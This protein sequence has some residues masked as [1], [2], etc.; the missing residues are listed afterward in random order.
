[1]S[2]F[3]FVLSFRNFIRLFYVFIFLFSLQT[4][5]QEFLWICMLIFDHVLN[6]M[7]TKRKFKLMIS[8]RCQ[9]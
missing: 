9:E 1:M 4:S 3:G 7:L 5:N 6:N 2:K 8:L